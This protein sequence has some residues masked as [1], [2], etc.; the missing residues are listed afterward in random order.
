[1]VKHML[2]QKLM[3]GD[4]PWKYARSGCKQARESKSHN[5]QSTIPLSFQEFK[6]LPLSEKV[7]QMKS[8]S[9]L[10]VKIL[11]SADQHLAIL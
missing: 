4:T 6:I 3:P 10:A 2:N 1:M 11:P 5:Q 9:V 8:G 7:H